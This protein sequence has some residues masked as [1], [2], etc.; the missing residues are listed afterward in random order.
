MCLYACMSSSKESTR[1]SG[2]Q[3]EPREKL[4]DGFL[5]ASRA[6][7]GV[8]VRSIDAAEP[9]VT[10]PQHRLLV[11]L[12]AR[13]PQLVGDLAA[14]LNVN[15]SSATRQ[16]DRLERRGLV[17]RDRSTTDRRSV[18]VSLT[19]PGR[20]LLHT[21][22]E[23]RRTEIATILD[24]MPDDQV[25]GA[26]AALRAFSEAAGELDDGDWLDG[27]SPTWTDRTP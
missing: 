18:V 2:A 14:E 19:A 8:A 11:L 20:S 5:T 13:G 12:A 7:V 1:Q 24:R 15:S 9:P 22:T 23:I 6:L 21:V 25:P 17:A 16:C 4:V 27:R 26:L 3:V 10:A